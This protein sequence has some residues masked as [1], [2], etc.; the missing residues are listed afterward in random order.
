[1]TVTKCTSSA[2]SL[3]HRNP[4]LLSE[5]AKFQN[6][7]PEPDSGD[8]RAAERADVSLDSEA[9]FAIGQL[10]LAGPAARG[11]RAGAGGLCA[12]WMRR[13]SAF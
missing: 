8:G 13:S 4:R 6:R 3:I 10:P 9:V 1:M 2:T 12:A 11:A 5:I 7:A